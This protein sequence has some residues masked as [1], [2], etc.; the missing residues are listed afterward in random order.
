MLCVEELKGRRGHKEQAKGI[1]VALSFRLWGDP[2][3]TALP[4]RLPEPRQE[5][6]LRRVARLERRADR[7]TPDAAARCAL[8]QVCGQHLPQQPVCRAAPY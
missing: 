6:V 2:E 7:R 8:R 1:R 5:P 3:M 4:M